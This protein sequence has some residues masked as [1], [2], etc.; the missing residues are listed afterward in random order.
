MNRARY[1]GLSWNAVAR[2]SKRFSSLSAA[3]VKSSLS[4]NPSFTL[5][6]AVLMIP[7]TT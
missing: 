1:F 3:F 2:W 7:E 4:I 6:S 5:L